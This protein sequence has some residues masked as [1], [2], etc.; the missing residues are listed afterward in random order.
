MFKKRFK[1]WGIDKYDKRTQTSRDSKS[2]RPKGQ[3]CLRSYAAQIRA[4]S[5]EQLSTELVE[6]A[7]FL[8][9]AFMRSSVDSDLDSDCWRHPQHLLAFPSLDAHAAMDNIDLGLWYLDLENFSD[10]GWHLRA[11][12]ISLE[13]AVSNRGGLSMSDVVVLAIGGTCLFVYHQRLDMLKAYL[14][15]LS[16]LLAVSHTHHPFR[17]IV[18]TLHRLAH[19]VNPGQLVTNTFRHYLI[20]ATEIHLDSLDRYVNDH[21]I[22]V[23]LDKIAEKASLSRLGLSNGNWTHLQIIADFDALIQSLV[24]CGKAD[25]DTVFL[26][27]E[28][29]LDHMLTSYC[30]PSDVVVRVEHLQHQLAADRPG[31]STVTRERSI[32]HAL[33]HAKGTLC[34]AG[35]FLQTG[36]TEAALQ[37]LPK[38]LGMYDLGMGEVAEGYGRLVLLAFQNRLDDSELRAD[39]AANLR[40]RRL[41]FDARRRSEMR[42]LVMEMGELK[43]GSQENEA[44]GD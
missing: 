6:K 2:R 11:G 17:H 38:V 21:E 16:G 42:G 44:S 26:I 33:I 29:I 18:D 27:Q 10:G 1:F 12:F 8:L 40:G 15:F 35:Y 3:R 5:H 9:R 37:V 4:I 25:E 20:A 31:V 24:E 13:R 41:E 22:R 14:S 19:L 28:V 43:I 34:L 32:W 23:H 39:D 7:A 36:K 30:F